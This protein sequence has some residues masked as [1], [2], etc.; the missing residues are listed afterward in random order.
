MEVLDS[1]WFHGGGI[2][3]VQTEYEG[4]KYYI[5]GMEHSF[6]PEVDAEWIAEWGNTFP[7]H[8]GDVLFGV[9][10]ES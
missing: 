1:Y 2:V 8:V 5:R 3:R 9:K 10:N 6:S 4:I 7:N